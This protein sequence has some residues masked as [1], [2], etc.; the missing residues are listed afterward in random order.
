MSPSRVGWCQVWGL[1]VWGLSLAAA[2]LRGQ[3]TVVVRQGTNG[4]QR[5]SGEIADYTGERLVLHLPDGRTEEIPADRVLAVETSRGADHEA[6]DRLYEAG[7]DAEAAQR[8]R[9]AGQHESRVWVQRM[10]LAQ[11]TRCYRNLDQ[12]DRAGETFLTLV[13][14]DRQTPWFEAI[15]LAW[16]AQAHS[17]EFVQTAAAW[18]TAAASPV[19]ALLG[20]SWLV[21]TPRREEA[22]QTL[23]RLAACD[24]PRV[25]S[26]AEAQ[27]WRGALVTVTADEAQRWRGRLDRIDPPLRAGPSF[28]VGQALARLNQPEQAALALLR[29]SILHPDQRGLAGEALLAAGQQVEKMADPDG[30]ARLYRELIDRYPRHLLAP[31]AERR[32]QQLTAK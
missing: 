11:L 22:L 1:L 8:Y 29:V 32:L 14:S 5:R 10:I 17:A 6:A 21:S 13:R 31:E 4:A 2:E 7:Q 24:D 12:P 27:R 28:V 3:D 19:S 20:A 30:A 26:L 16:T 18:M 9:Q 25:A 23:G 15:P